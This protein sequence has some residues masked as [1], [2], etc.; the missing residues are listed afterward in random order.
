[1]EIKI[2]IKENIIQINSKQD[3]YLTGDIAEKG[4]IFYVIK[5]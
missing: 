3:I 2:K 4:K 5:A 1:M